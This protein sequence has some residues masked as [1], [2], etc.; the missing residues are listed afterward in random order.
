MSTPLFHYL[1]IHWLIAF[2]P[3]GLGIFV[4]SRNSRNPLYWAFLRYNFVISWWGAFNLFMEYSPNEAV[5]LFWDRISLVGIVFIPAAFIHF[6]WMYSG[7]SRWYSFVIKCCYGLS[8]VF[9]LL[10]FTPYMARSATPKYIIPY[11]RQGDYSEGIYQGSLAIASIIAKDSGIELSAGPVQSEPQ[12]LP[13]ISTGQK[14][15]Y[16]IL[17]ACFLILIIRHPILFLFLLNSGNSRSY[18]GFGGGGFGGFGGGMSG[19]GGSSRS[20]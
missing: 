4:V 15:F 13:P 16:L 8:T 20:W 11:F 2:I 3:L 7:R 9:L 19:G 1:L 14:I 18:G 5:A 12:S 6:T 17:I 10:V